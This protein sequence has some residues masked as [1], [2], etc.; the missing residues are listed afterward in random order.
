VVSQILNPLSLSLPPPPQSMEIT[1]VN[2]FSPLII[3]IIKV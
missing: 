2:N 1:T 3:I